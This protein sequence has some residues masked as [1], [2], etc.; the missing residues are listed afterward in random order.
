MISFIRNYIQLLILLIIWTVVP[1]YGG[2]VVAYSIVGISIVLF[3]FSKNYLALFFGFFYI[4]LLSDNL[5][6]GLFFA[7]S[8]KNVYMV[9]M[10]VT[11]IMNKKDFEPF[12]SLFNLFIPFLIIAVFALQFSGKVDV[13][14]QKTLSYL[15]LLI[16]IPNYVKCLYRQ[17]GAEFL[18]DLIN[19]FV[20][21]IVIGYFVKFIS[22][23]FAY[24]QGNRMR[25]M[26]GN[27]NGLGIFLFLFASFYSIVTSFFPKLFSLNEK[28]F[29]FVVIG[30]AL[31]LCGSRT[32]FFSIFIL[33][34]FARI[35]NRSPFLGLI[36]LVGIIFSYEY[37]L[38]NAI[39]LITYGGLQD[40][41]R[42]NTLEEGSGRFIAW[43]F[44]WEKIQNFYYFG[45]GL[46]NDEFIMRQHYGILTKLGHQGGVHNS[47]LTL[48]FDTGIIGVILYVR[49]L[50]LAFIKGVK[51]S[52]L[53][54]PF[55]YS[56]LFSI[57]Y[58]SWIAGSLN[59]F[60]I[61]LFLSLTLIYEDEFV[62]EEIHDLAQEDKTI[63]SVN[64]T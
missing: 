25:G 44:A 5:D 30:L 6:E 14:I 64:L 20:L 41:F 43:G 38:A 40:Y 57:T 55:F 53:A 52:K 54:I 27:P 2:T 19:F 62:P 59:P 61:V 7:K 49:G 21:I 58:E 17:H 26:F 23:D 47:Y 51:K 29:I 22:F 1:F 32:A 33:L 37:L 56:V 13:G 39:N 42:I 31:F 4:L 18:K 46:G 24:I 50:F 48:W 15:L 9:F 10:G 8:F 3:V 28:R 12:S 45:G 63:Q 36:L 35:Q 60:T 34:F 16:T 11:L